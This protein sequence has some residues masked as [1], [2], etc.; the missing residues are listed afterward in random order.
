MSTKAEIRRRSLENVPKDLLQQPFAALERK[1]PITMQTFTNIRTAY[2][3][4]LENLTR[5]QKGLYQ[6]ECECRMSR[7]T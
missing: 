4:W 1:M 2:S 6:P 5:H 3:F 7:N